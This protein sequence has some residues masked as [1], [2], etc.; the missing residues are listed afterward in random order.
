VVGFVI[1][2]GI[3]VRVVLESEFLL[4]HDIS[5]HLSLGAVLTEQF[6]KDDVVSSQVTVYFNSRLFG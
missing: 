1:S 5:V 4:C 3:G 6:G 2:V